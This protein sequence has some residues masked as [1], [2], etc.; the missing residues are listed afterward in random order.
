MCLSIG[1]HR[2]V[3]DGIDWR[4]HFG[5]VLSSDNRDH[6]RA[7]KKGV[8]TY[9]S[10]E[11]TNR[12]AGCAWSGI[13]GRHEDIRFDRHGCYFAPALVSRIQHL[14]SRPETVQP[15]RAI[16]TTVSLMW[17]ARGR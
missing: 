9:D 11:A 4:I 16:A 8:G 6:G 2:E 15:S 10:G 1:N 5:Q 14:A 7:P 12:L 13:G 3:D 17:H